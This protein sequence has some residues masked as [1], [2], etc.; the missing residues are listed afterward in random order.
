MS[1]KK[2]KGKKGT[3]LDKIRK[4]YFLHGQIFSALLRFAAPFESLKILAQGGTAAPGSPLT[5]PPLIWTHKNEVFYNL[6]DN[7]NTIYLIEFD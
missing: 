7:A 5:R 2:K 4:K 1:G 6:L 3:P